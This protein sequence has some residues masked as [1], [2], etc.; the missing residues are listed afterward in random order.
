MKALSIFIICLTLGIFYNLAM[1]QQNKFDAKL[2]KIDAVENNMIHETSIGSYLDPYVDIEEDFSMEVTGKE[3]RYL[4]TGLSY[5]EHEYQS[6]KKHVMV[7]QT[8]QRHSSLSG[9]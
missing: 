9:S 1:Y 4:N 2:Q 5:I 3:H 6:K 8:E 7:A